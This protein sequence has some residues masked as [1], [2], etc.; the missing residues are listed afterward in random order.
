MVLAQASRVVRRRRRPPQ[1]RQQMVGP[2]GGVVRRSGAR[3]AARTLPLP[4]VGRDTQAGRAQ[5]G[6][7]AG[8]APSR[9]PP[10]PRRCATPWRRRAGP[11]TRR[12]RAAAVQ[13][14]GEPGVGS[15]SAP[16]LVQQSLGVGELALATKISARVRRAYR[17]SATGRFSGAPV[18]AAP[19]ASRNAPATP[20]GGGVVGEHLACRVFSTPCSLARARPSV[21][22]LA[23]SPPDG[24]RVPGRRR[25]CRTPGR[26]PPDGRRPALSPPRTGAH[27]SPSSTRPRKVRAR[28]RLFSARPSSARAPTGRARSVARCARSNPG[29]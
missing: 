2:R 29:E 10:G 28:P 4:E 15:A 26:G 7:D 1:R 22:S 25:G 14:S 21:I 8:L 12:T 6:D 5:L 3:P 16:D 18:R 20:G 23:T 11:A 27:F 19:A 9:P 17:L 24:R 13:R